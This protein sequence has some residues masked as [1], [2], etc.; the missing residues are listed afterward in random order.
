LVAVSL[1]DEAWGM[2]NTD[3]ELNDVLL[4]GEGYFGYLAGVMGHTLEARNVYG[5]WKPLARELTVPRYAS[6]GLIMEWVK[7]SLLSNGW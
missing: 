5:N 2:A 3:R 6:R 7:Q 1:R 4:L